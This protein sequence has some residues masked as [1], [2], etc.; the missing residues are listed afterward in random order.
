MGDAKSCS[1]DIE[2]LEV[3]WCSHQQHE[4][5]T[6]VSKVS[7]VSRKRHELVIRGLR[8]KVQSEISVA[9]GQQDQQ[10]AEVLVMVP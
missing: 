7:R 2:V 6:V 10:M 4:D 1:A 5:T 9:G 3:H 8:L